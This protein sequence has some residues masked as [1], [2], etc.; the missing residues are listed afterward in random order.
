MKRDVARVFVALKNNTSTLCGYYSL[1][2]ASF[3]RDSL[4]P[5][6]AKRLPHYPVPAALL[7]RLAVDHSMK[8]KGLGAFL[9]MDA[10]NRILLATQTLAVNAVIVDA[11]D[12]AAAAFYRKYGFIPFNRS[13]KRLFLPMATIRRLAGGT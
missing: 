8:G 9:L 4:P 3:Q 7:G 11:K 2:A 6:Q 10:L 5:D 12:N 13:E 1:S